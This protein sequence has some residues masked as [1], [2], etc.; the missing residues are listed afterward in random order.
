MALNILRANTGA[1]PTLRNTNTQTIETMVKIL[2]YKV[3][4]MKVEQSIQHVRLLVL[5]NS[6]VFKCFTVVVT[7]LIVYL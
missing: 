3:L 6:M 5:V 2:Y 1:R 7:F 4:F